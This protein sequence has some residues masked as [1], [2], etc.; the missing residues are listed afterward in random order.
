[1]L[2]RVLI[3]YCAVFLIACFASASCRGIDS[4]TWCDFPGPQI[5]HAAAQMRQVN[6]V[7]GNVLLSLLF[8]ILF[9]LF[10]YKAVQDIN[11]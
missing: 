11:F 10:A 7:V 9:L 5:Q 8:A 4:I 2:P 1:M 3:Y 6:A